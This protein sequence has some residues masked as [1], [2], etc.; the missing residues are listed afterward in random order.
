MR[1][2]LRHLE[3][4]QLFA[5]ILNVTETA[6]ILRVTQPSVSQALR[7]FEAQMGVTLLL[8]T[9]SGLRLTP[10]AEVLLNDIDTVL[11]SLQR[12][13]DRAMRLKGEENSKLVIA[14]V[15][16]LTGAIIPRAVQ[17]LRDG[18]PGTRFTI[19]T[20]SSRDVIAKVQDHSV[21]VGLTFLPVDVPD[22]IQHPLMTVEMACLLP[23]GHRLA[24][25]AE[26]TA[27]DLRDEV[28]INLG[29]QIR[30]EFDARLVFDRPLDDP[31]F[32]TT[33]LSSVAADLVR[34]GV[35]VAISLPFVIRQ[36]HEDDMVLRPFTPKI[37]RS[38]VAIFPPH[39]G[40]STVGR[41]FLRQIH[42][43]LRDFAR[44]LSDIGIKSRVAAS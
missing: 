34:Q 33:N 16:P 22:L 12:L 29:A 37:R 44:E 28:I 6:R 27:D 3:I 24:Q 17:A 15:M 8:R 1:P 39:P 40:L 13:N 43:E 32:V 5:R 18:A 31:R 23:A 25:H 11:D 26:I 20:Y 42:L 10:A 21:D 36:M 4:F 2:S 30:Q 35:G 9:K 38:L 19:E 7:D 41:Q 14:S